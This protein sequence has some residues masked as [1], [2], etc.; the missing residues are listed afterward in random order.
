MGPHFRSTKMSMRSGNPPTHCWWLADFSCSPSGEHQSQ[1]QAWAAEKKPTLPLYSFAE[2]S[3]FAFVRAVSTAQASK[4]SFHSPESYTNSFSSLY[5][6]IC[7]IATRL[8]SQI[9]YHILVLDTRMV[10]LRCVFLY[11]LQECQPFWKTSNSLR[12]DTLG[13]LMPSDRQRAFWARICT[14]KLYGSLGIRIYRAWLVALPPW[15]LVDAIDWD[16]YM[17]KLLFTKETIRLKTLKFF[18]SGGD[19]CFSGK[20]GFMLENLLN[21]MNK[22]S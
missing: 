9:S 2:N 6:S 5:A 8:Y 16:C 19:A 14:R 7:G 18:S 22:R 10:F 13:F 17:W 1:N 4:N 11:D 15:F 3:V 20:M 21:S 12:K